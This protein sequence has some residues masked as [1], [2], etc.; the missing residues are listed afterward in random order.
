M[1][2]KAEKLNFLIKGDNDAKYPAFKS[3]IESFKKNEIYKYQLITTPE[4]VPPGSELEKENQ[5]KRQAD[6]QKKIIKN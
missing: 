2:R 3:V 5:K 6:K 4:G 1:H